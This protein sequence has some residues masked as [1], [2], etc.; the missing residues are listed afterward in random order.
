[1]SFIRRYKKGGKVYLAEVESI[2][3]DGKVKQRYI[4]HIG[5][6]ADGKTILSCSIS[7]AKME[8]V[9]LSGPIMV[10]HALANKIGLEDYLGQYSKEILS[11]VYAHCI[12]YKSLNKMVTWFERTDLNMILDLEELTERRLVNSLDSIEKMDLIQIQQDLFKSVRENFNISTGGI[13]Y[14]V[15]N[16]YFHG[17]KCTGAKY[18]HDKE[19]RKGYPLVQIGL[20][21][22]QEQGVP[23]FHKTFPGNI[24]DSRT[25]LDISN[26]LKGFGIKKGIAIIDRGT[27]SGINTDYLRREKWDV[28]CGIPINESI[29]KDI[30]KN[31]VISKIARLKNRIRLNNTVLYCVEKRFKH[32]NTVGKL[33][34]CFNKKKAQ[35]SLES[36]Y[37]ELESARLRLE[38]GKTIKSELLRFFNKKNQIVDSKVED[39]TSYSG[40]SFIFTTSKMALPNIIHSYFDKDVV[41][42]SFQSLKGVIRLR[43]IRHWLY[44]RVEAHIFICF[45]SYLLL[46]LLKL[47]VNKLE[48]SFQRALDELDGLYRIYIKDPKSGYRMDRLIA[49]SKIQEKILRVVDKS[50]LSKCSE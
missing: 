35:E 6:E 33:I 23:I 47:K 16:T 45:L 8:S 15:T 31:D 43:P 10:L 25:F 21:V 37:D 22:T 7:E 26:E 13:I 40:L 46:S 30:K 41:E 9:K 24:S 17:K 42:K 38:A 28:L 39:T 50:L 12:D 2:R 32:G 1:M 44:N 34:T 48:M 27:S 29:K 20:A 36:L 4:R 14:D 3:V 19:K 18:G 11:M 49:L 5:R